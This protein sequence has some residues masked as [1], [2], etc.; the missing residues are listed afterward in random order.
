MASHAI[1]YFAMPVS[2]RQEIGDVGSPLSSAESGKTSKFRDRGEV[3]EASSHQALLNELLESDLSSEDFQAAQEALL[4]DWI[5]RDLR[6]AL[7]LFFLPES[8]PRYRELVE[9]SD[10]LSKKLDEEISRQSEAVWEW[11]LGGRFGSSRAELTKLWNSALVAHGQRDFVLASLGQ[12][13]LDGQAHAAT[14]LCKRAN[15]EE[16]DRIRELLDA[17][18]IEHNDRSE[19]L[20][21]YIARR[22]GLAGDDVAPVFSKEDDPE[23]REE[24][25]GRWVSSELDG[26][27]AKEI[28]SRLAACPGDLLANAVSQINANFPGRMK[29][30]VEFVEE[31][32]GRNAWIQSDASAVRD[33][34][35]SLVREN[36]TGAVNPSEAFSSLAGISDRSLREE[37]LKALGEQF[38]DAGDGAVT[39][40][41]IAS[42]PNNANRGQMITGFV[43]GLDED[44]PVLN[45]ALAL[46]QDPAIRDGLL[47][48]RRED[49]KASD[50]K[51]RIWAKEYEAVDQKKLDE[52]AKQESTLPEL[53]P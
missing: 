5:K 8:P 7:E 41:A 51:L 1:A 16:L 32:S 43:L 47:E 38:A 46:I 44:L 17:R 33:A 36:Y 26:L 6:G 4:A 34:I 45:A 49:Q 40:Q 20:D 12:G 10:L 29:D 42:L 37:A 39:L 50:E 35:A 52:A 2:E 21:A 27:T 53:G 48:K 14:L 3:S 19:I 30:L 18:L 25:C 13:S 31:L 28:A 11:I 24:L 23:I 9:E 15:A 22:I